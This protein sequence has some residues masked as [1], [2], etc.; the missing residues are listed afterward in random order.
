VVDQKYGL[1]EGSAV[2]MLANMQA[3]FVRDPTN[4]QCSF[5]MSDYFGIHGLGLIHIT[6]PHTCLIRN[7]RTVNPKVDREYREPAVAWST[8]KGRRALRRALLRQGFARVYA[9]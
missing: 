8:P 6:S 4:M 5:V 3:E 9:M 2:G 7:G 1:K